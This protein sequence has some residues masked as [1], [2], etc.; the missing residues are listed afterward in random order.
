MTTTVSTTNVHINVWP[1]EGTGAPCQY[2]DLEV[3]VG[4]DTNNI[5]IKQYSHLCSTKSYAQYKLGRSS[6][7]V[8]TSELLSTGEHILSLETHEGIPATTSINTEGSPNS[9]GE[10]LTTIMMS[11]TLVDTCIPASS[12]VDII[13][14]DAANQ[15]ENTA[16]ILDAFTNLSFG[17]GGRSTISVSSTASIEFAS[18]SGAELDRMFSISIES[19]HSTQSKYADCVYTEQPRDGDPDCA[20]LRP[21]PTAGKQNCT[22]PT[23]TQLPPYENEQDLKRVIE[24]QAAFWGKEYG[25]NAA[26]PSKPV[27]L[28]KQQSAFRQDRSTTAW[29]GFAAQHGGQGQ[30]LQKAGHSPA[31]TQRSPIHPPTEPKHGDKTGGYCLNPKR[32]YTRSDGDIGLKDRQQ[33]KDQRRHRGFALPPHVKSR[34]GTHWGKSPVEQQE[35][36]EGPFKHIERQYW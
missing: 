18:I 8:T 26:K 24:P 11:C 34:A 27:S 23:N 17:D 10:E 12:R 29:T 5:I 3:C 28:P 6:F 4:L 2:P 21:V 1:A 36:T 32:D 15:S 30:G 31:A 13:I 16:L 20:Y 19:S 35:Y 14:T 25:M 22:L 33:K 7:S 9:T